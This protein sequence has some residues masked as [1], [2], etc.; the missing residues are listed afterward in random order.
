MQSIVGIFFQ[1]KNESSLKGIFVL[2]LA[3][4]DWTYNLNVNI[5]CFLKITL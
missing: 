2:Y 4:I 3:K 1:N 5:L